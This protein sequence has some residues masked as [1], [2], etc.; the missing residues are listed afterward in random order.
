[1]STVYHNKYKNKCIKLLDNIESQIYF[2][3]QVGS[4]DSL[5]KI[6]KSGM[7]KKGA[8]L[9]KKER[10]LS[11]GIPKN[12]IFC[13][14]HFNDSRIKVPITSLIIKADVINENITIFNPVWYG[15]VYEKS[16][17]IKENSTCEEI[18]AG[19]FT[20]KQK[21]DDDVASKLE[22]VNIKIMSHEILFEK[23]IDVKKYI[24][25]IICHVDDASII[26]K[27]LK[28]YGHEDIELISQSENEAKNYNELKI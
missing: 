22:K 20:I 7:I 11:G 17:I 26:K 1:M 25:K 18:I 4:L 9:T 27:W 15:S 6:L 21:Y 14:I 28:K 23:T 13:N 2:S 12:Y 3:H 8:D 5:K 16:V 24:D 10:K 19:I